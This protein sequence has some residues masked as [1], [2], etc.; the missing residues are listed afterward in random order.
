MKTK[1]AD[2]CP[3]VGDMHSKVGHVYPKAWDRTCDMSLA[4]L[5]QILKNFIICILQLFCKCLLGGKLMSCGR[6][7][8]LWQS[9]NEEGAILD[10]FSDSFE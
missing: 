8:V 7:A 5:Q 3:K 4:F 10:N 9:N 6:I 2:R 1:L